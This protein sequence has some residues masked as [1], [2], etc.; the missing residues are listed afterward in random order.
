MYAA[1]G[2]LV[3]E[4][5]LEPLLQPGEEWF[6]GE[7]GD[8]GDGNRLG[9]TTKAMVKIVEQGQKIVEEGCALLIYIGAIGCHFGVVVVEFGSVG[10]GFV[11]LYLQPCIAL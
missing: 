2:A 8:V 10:S 11:G 3:A 5:V 9:T 6:L 4:V 7:V 1:E